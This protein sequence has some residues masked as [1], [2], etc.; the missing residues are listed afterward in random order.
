MTITDPHQHVHP[1]PETHL[2]PEEQEWVDAFMNDTTLFIGPDPEIMREHSIAKRSS[3]E[4]RV[5]KQK[6]DPLLADR[7][8]RRLAGALDEAFEMCESM[9][10][11]PGAKWADLS[12]AVY[13]AAGD[14]AYMSNRGVIA[15]SAVLHHPIRHIIK[16][17]KDEP[18]VGINPGDGFFHNDAR[19]GM[20]HNT[21]QSMLM[22]VMRE[23]EIIAW[24][25]ATIHEGE[26]GA[27]EPGGM[28]SGSETPFD[29]G[30]RGSPMK[31]VESG[32][33]RR[34]L[35]TFLQHSTRDPKLMLADIKVKMGAVKRVM[36]IVDQAI[37]EHG[38]E[39]FVG[40][41]RMTVERRCAG[42]R[43]GARH[44]RPAAGPDL[45]AGGSRH[46][47]RRVGA[48]NL[49][50]RRRGD[51]EDARGRAA[52]SPQ[53]RQA[54]LRVRRGVRQGGAAGGPG[55]LRLVGPGQ[56]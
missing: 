42:A 33:L 15:F 19:F 22:P 27:C 6:S 12:V 29:D 2:T 38:V 25:G 50:R 21:D 3:L 30:L 32:R 28:P 16:Y 26:N 17:W 41:I 44:D 51:E 20:V 8:R 24:V 9:G 40:A 54:L 7:I 11:A 39:P 46:L 5:L 31:I 36:D 48:G 47:P 45:R 4:D 56:R 49:R 43:P 53:A 10:A 35:L 18:T 13:T 52:G 55:L 34:D 1:T 23:G 37:E 14:V